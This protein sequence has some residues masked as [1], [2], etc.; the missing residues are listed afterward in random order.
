MAKARAIAKRRKAVNN[1]RKITRTMELIATNRFRKALNR[2]TEAE[3]YTRKIAELVADLGNTSEEFTHPL[4]VRRD[5]VRRSLLLVLSSNRGL[6]GGYNGNVLRAAS[7]RLQDNQTEGTETSLEVA[8][9]RGIGYFRFR[10]MA[11]DASYTQFEDRPQFGEIEVM[12]ERY[13]KM[14]LQGTIDRL[15]VAFTQFVSASRQIATVQTL[16]PITTSDIGKLAQ[17]VRQAKPTATADAPAPP[18]KAEPV[19]YEFLPDPRSILEEI[20][21]VSF[22]VRLFKCFLDAAVSEQIARMVA[23]GGA[24]KNADDLSKSLTRQYNRARQ[25]QITRELADI[26]GAAAALK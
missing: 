18:K 22:K 14:F 24:T 7:V 4:L 5:P 19:P 3:T 17:P 6:A 1:I 23:M 15:D 9:K 13:I 10:K 8:G 11:T 26:V 12:A 21:P 2:A 16:L 20:V 25:N